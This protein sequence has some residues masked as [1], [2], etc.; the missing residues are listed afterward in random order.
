MHNHVNRGEVSSSEAPAAAAAAALRSKSGD[1]N[2]S[3][4]S[5]DAAGYAED[6]DRYCSNSFGSRASYNAAQ[7][8]CIVQSTQQPQYQSSSITASQVVLKSLSRYSIEVG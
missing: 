2:S 7:Y 8:R 4:V 6:A 3:S 1:V 5:A